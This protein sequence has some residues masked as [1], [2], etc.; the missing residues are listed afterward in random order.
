VTGCSRINASS[1]GMKFLLWLLLMPLPSLQWR[2]RLEMQGGVPIASE[3][4]AF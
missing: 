1:D 2:V 4:I 3:R